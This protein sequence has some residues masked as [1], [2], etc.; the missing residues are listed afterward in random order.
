MATRADYGSSLTTRCETTAHDA[1]QSVIRP[2]VRRAYR[3]QDMQ[4]DIDRLLN[5]FDRAQASGKSYAESMRWVLK[6]G[7]RIAKVP[8]SMPSVTV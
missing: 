6:G 8:V 1:A 7:T 2:F 5:L 3:G 4:A